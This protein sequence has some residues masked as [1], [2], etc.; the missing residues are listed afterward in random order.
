MILCM[1]VL[2]NP[3]W[4]FVCKFQTAHY[5]TLYVSSRQPIIRKTT[6]ALW[7]EVLVRPLLALCMRFSKWKIKRWIYQ[8]HGINMISFFCFIVSAKRYIVFVK[9]INIGIIKT[10]SSLYALFSKYSICHG[11]LSCDHFIWS[12][13]FYCSC[14]YQQL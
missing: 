3:L 4:H 6:K 8:Y 14:F 1:Q 12:H 5:G 10:W 9:L 11:I 7:M 2:N 13:K